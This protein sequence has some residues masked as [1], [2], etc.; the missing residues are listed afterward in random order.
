MRRKI[1]IICID[2][3]GPDYLEG[4]STPNIDRMAS[5]GSFVIGRSVIPSVTNVNNA[6]IITGAPPSVHGI[7]SNYW[8]DRVTGEEKY[9]ESAGFLCTPTILERARHLGKS[10]ALLTC[11]EK[12]SH[13]LDTGSDYTL[14]A[15]N[16]DEGM[17]GKIGPA[18]GIYTSEINLWLLKALRVLLREQDPDVVY[19]STTDFVMH[20][21]GPD[22]EESLRYIRDLDSLLGKILDDHPSR[23]T[24]LTAD[25]G[26]TAKTCGVDLQRVLEGEGIRA[27]SI[28]IIK[29]LYTE[30]HQNLGGAS[31][32]YVERQDLISEAAGILA[33]SK[34]VEEVFLREDAAKQFDLM[35]DRIGDLLALGGR[36]TVFGSFDKA[37]M[38]VQV[39]SHGSRYEGEVP[40]IA[41]GSKSSTP[42]RKNYDIVARMELH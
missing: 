18:P 42:Y 12:L 35:A 21:Y 11:K 34:G 38:G 40:I 13:L 4:S 23:E 19:C 25:H 28:P 22:Q 7:T 31:Y 36:D 6:S 27:R 10:T 5:A 9:M 33:Q 32:V 3:F 37:E 24:Y 39:R 41:F 26:M 29:D 15:E 20:K 8:F 16:P 14:A 30:H 2:G 1:L 17:V